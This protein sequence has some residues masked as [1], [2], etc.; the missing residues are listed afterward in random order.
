MSIPF[1]ITRVPTSIDDQVTRTFGRLFLQIKKM[2][3]S[4][5]F[6]VNNYDLLKCQFLELTEIFLSHLQTVT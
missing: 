3:R 2:L 4:S 5:P 6:Y 1:S